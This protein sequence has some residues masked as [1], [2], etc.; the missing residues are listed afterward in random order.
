MKQKLIDI[1][2][3]HCPQHVYLQGTMNPEEEYPA[4]FVTFWT[5]STDDAAHYDNAVIAVD[6]TFYVIYYSNDP[7]KVNTKPFEIAA[8]LK[9][10]GFVPQGKGI[11][12]LSDKNSHTGWAMEFTYSEKQ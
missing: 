9:S 7:R 5:P 4:E 12:I 8:A 10:A 6:W 3:K 1:L 2:E 11:D